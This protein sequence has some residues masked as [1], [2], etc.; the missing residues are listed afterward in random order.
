MMTA[1]NEWMFLRLFFYR[2][3]LSSLKKIVYTQR[4][5]A[6]TSLRLLKTSAPRLIDSDHIK[7]K[8]KVK[9]ADD[10]KI[11]REKKI[12]RYCCLG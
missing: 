10:L 2:S 8:A 7:S 5:F 12:V 6:I 1:G 3:I 4:P 9:A 11:G